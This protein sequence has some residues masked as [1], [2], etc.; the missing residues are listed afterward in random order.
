MEGDLFFIDDAS[1]KGVRFMA[2]CSSCCVSGGREE[3]EDGVRGEGR[4]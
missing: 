1:Q 2:C 3:V 4:G